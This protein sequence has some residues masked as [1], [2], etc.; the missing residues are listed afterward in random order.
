MEIQY[1]PRCVVQLQTQR[2]DLMTSFFTRF[3]YVRMLTFLNKGFF[4]KNT[5]V[6]T[7]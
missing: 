3:I 5:A 6:F 2:L 7:L 1:G 4:H